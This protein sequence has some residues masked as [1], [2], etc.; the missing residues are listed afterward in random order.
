MR[1]AACLIG[2]FLFTNLPALAPALLAQTRNEVIGGGYELPPPL[3]VAPGQL[4][5]LFVRGMSNREAVAAS[6]P[7]P[8]TL[9]GITV[10]LQGKVA[11]PSGFLQP[12]TQPGTWQWVRFPP[13]PI[14][15]I[16][17]MC[18]GEGVD[19]YACTL[20]RRNKGKDACE[21]TCRN[22][23]C[24]T[25]AITVQF[26]FD[27]ISCGTGFYDPCVELY[28]IA[29]RI[30]VVEDGVPGASF[31]AQTV[32]G[33]L[34]IVNS[35]D[36]IARLFSSDSGSECLP[37]V[38]RPDGSLISWRNPAKTGEVVSV[39]LTGL[40]IEKGER[41]LLVNFA[42]G[43][44]A[45]AIPPDPYSSAATKA[46]YAGPAPGFAGLYQVNVKLPDRLPQMPQCA[47]GGM[48]NVNLAL[49]GSIPAYPPLSL[50]SVVS[51]G[52]CVQP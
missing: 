34:H 11:V 2:L 7:L 13:L 3:A 12:G 19:P 44:L 42:F 38:R 23:V 30:T 16:H 31:D 25:A 32:F 10:E 21:D 20:C 27:L 36:S 37:M 14:F 47:S 5:T 22:G 46:L 49:L 8:T 4:I 18:R 52:I 28:P 40:G 17:R 35:C 26:P 1:K 43:P 29:L 41:G 15:G 24:D 39:Y 48:Y 50:Y 6:L 51:A 45:P 9:A 33:N